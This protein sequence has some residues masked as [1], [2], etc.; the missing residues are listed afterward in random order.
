VDREGFHPH[1]TKNGQCP[2][3]ALF[4]VDEP[5]V[6]DFPEAVEKKVVPYAKR[7]EEPLLFPLLGKVGDPFLEGF[8]R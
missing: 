2:L 5:A 6:A 4:P 8:R 7:P 1:V 3:L